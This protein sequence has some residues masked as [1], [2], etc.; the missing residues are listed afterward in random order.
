MLVGLE[1]TAPSRRGPC[2]PASVREHLEELAELVRSAGA[3]AVETALQRLPAPTP[4]HFIGR[5]KAEE[6]AGF[7]RSANLNLI[8]FDEEL[9]PAQTRNLEG[10][11]GAK[12]VDRT[13]LI[14]DIFAQRAQSREG[15]LQIEL[16]QLQYT[17]PRLT[18]M[19]AH[20]SR[21]QG[22]I[23]TRGPGETQLEVDRRRIQE[24]IARLKRDL[25]E[26]RQTRQVQRKARR[27]RHWPVVALVGYTNAGKSTL[28]NALTGADAHVE[29]KLFATLDPLTR[30]LML[31]DKQSVLLTD[32]VGFI[33]KLPHGL[34]ES[35]KATLE[36]V[37]EADLLIHV[38]DVSHPAV[39]EQL[40]A[41]EEVLAE[42]GAREK[43]RLTALNKVDRIAPGHGMLE[44]LLQEQPRAVALS[45]A[46]GLGLDALKDELSA[47]LRPLRRTTTLKIPANHAALLA[48]LYAEAQILGRCDEDNVVRLTARVAPDLYH[49]L[50]GF[51][52]ETANG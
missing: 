49:D 46:A 19:W 50:E 30:R 39:E 27:R 22:G 12:V 16:A 44:R 38:V 31:P 4:S 48:R 20:F 15:R 17:L 47:Q 29:D 9:S 13:G 52:D 45:A 2:A 11:F 36:E 33:R 3:E 34:V 18:H 5:G 23:G 41:V 1:L 26:V 24:R 21:Q 43:P 6:L 14:L 10:V 51:V 28:L 7:A 37:S 35:F 8:V 25:E 32:T 42:L 40:A